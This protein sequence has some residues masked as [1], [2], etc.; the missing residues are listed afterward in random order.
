M[1]TNSISRYNPLVPALLE[2]RHR[3]RILTQE[4][5]NIDLKS[6]S[7]EGIGDKRMEILRKL[8]GRIG[9]NTFI[10]TPFMPDYGSNIIIGK[11]CF[12]NWK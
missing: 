8:I 10:E 6:V 4:L 2:G 12:I 9:E 7:Y 3:A 5:N 1:D 11:N